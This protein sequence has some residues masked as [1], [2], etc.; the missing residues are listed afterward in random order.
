MELEEGR[1]RDRDLELFL[2]ASV[3]CCGLFYDSSSSSLFCILSESG[4]FYRRLG[5]AAYFA[6]SSILK[7]CSGN[8][9]G[10]GW[11]CY[12]ALLIP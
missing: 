11:A 1:S 7:V 5:L 9:F 10:V 6:S 4:G 12:F 8:P 3:C 2:R